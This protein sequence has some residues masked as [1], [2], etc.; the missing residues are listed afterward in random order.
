MAQELQLGKDRSLHNVSIKQI[1]TGTMRSTDNYISINYTKMKHLSL[2]GT[3]VNIK[4]TEKENEH[5]H[6]TINI[7]DYTGTISIK[8]V[9]TQIKDITT[10]N[11]LESLKYVSNILQYKQ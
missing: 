4:V 10:Q 2:I 9:H 3:I 7:S 8:Y 6:T 5:I 1:L 11:R